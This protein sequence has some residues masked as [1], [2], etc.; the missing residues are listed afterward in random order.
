MYNNL[1]YK[2]FV[3]YIRLLYIITPNPLV[4]ILVIFMIFIILLI[5]IIIIL[6]QTV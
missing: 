6:G 5:T 4:P 2:I 1:I 3:L